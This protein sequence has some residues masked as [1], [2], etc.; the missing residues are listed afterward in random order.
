MT[1]EILVVLIRR[2]SDM[3]VVVAA[4][5]V[6]RWLCT[7]PPRRTQTYNVFQQVITTP[8]REYR[9]VHMHAVTW[10]SFNQGKVQCLPTDTPCAL[11]VVVAGSRTMGKI[12]ITLWQNHYCKG[13]LH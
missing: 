5:A 1:I 8:H 12:V 9:V 10:K 11:C 13:F 7:P 6:T 2:A 4:P 3:N